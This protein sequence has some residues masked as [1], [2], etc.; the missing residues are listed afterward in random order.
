[1]FCFGFSSV[2]RKFNTFENC[3]R[4]H[5]CNEKKK[6]LFGFLRKII[7]K[8]SDADCPTLT[9]DIFQEFIQSILGLVFAKILRNE[10]IWNFR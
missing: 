7:L 8:F 9:L 6:K 2:D 10:F 1:M 5:I 4:V 3:L